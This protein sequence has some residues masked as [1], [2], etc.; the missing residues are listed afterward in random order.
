MTVLRTPR[1]LLRPPRSEDATYIAD[2]INNERISRNLARVPFPCTLDDVRNWLAVLSHEAHDAHVFA[3]TRG[4]EPI[5]V[6]GLEGD[7]HSDT[8]E[9]G[10]WLGEPWWRGGW[11][12]EAAFAVVR[13][14]FEDLCF[15]RVTAGYRRGNEASR[16]L[17]LH[18]GFRITGHTRMYSRGSRAVVEVARTEI[19]RREWLRGGCR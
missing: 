19:T 10:Y 6:I 18:L 3:L 5:G 7:D 17:L 11:M 13:H 2:L 4:P 14:G 9:L 8:A 1:L 12:S 15:E 16:R